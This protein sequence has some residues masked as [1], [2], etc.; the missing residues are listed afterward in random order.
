M[1]MIGFVMKGGKPFQILHG[2]VK[3]FREVLRLGAKHIPPA[4]PVVVAEPFRILPAK[5]NDC[6]PDVST[7]LIELGGNLRELDRDAAIGEQSMGSE[8]FGSGPGGNIVSVCFCIQRLVCVFL[9]RSGNEFR[10]S[11]DSLCL[12]II[13]ML[14]AVSAVREVLQQAP[15][16]LLLLLRGNEGEAL[17]FA[18]LVR[19]LREG[20]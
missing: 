14:Q 5:R 11:A 12:Q 6:G 7:V 8:A 17:R 18:S 13:L 9:Y 1:R 15:D 16:Q 19:P 10:G 2:N 3:R 4:F 20:L